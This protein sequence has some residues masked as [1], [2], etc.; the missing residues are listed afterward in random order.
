MEHRIQH[1]RGTAA[2]WT[3]ANPILASGEPGFETDTHKSKIGDGTSHWA[4][5]PYAPTLPDIGSAQ[6]ASL[7]KAA[8]LSDLAS[9]SSARTNLGLGSAATQPSSAFDAAGAAA[10]VQ[11][12]NRLALARNPDLLVTGVI[13]RDANGAA[14]SAPVTWPDGSPGNYTALTVS[15]AFPGAVDSYKVTYGSPVSKTYTQPAITRDANGAATNVPQ[16][17]AS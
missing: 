8:N 3:T 2:Q 1:R 14:T 9:A 6:G 13:T 17:V 12:A 7:Q 11:V 10:A 5:L 16:I 4:D 15:T